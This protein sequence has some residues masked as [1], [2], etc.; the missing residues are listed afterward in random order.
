M[1]STESSEYW[2]VGLATTYLIGVLQSCWII[3]CDAA[4]SNREDTLVLTLP[5]VFGH[6]EATDVL[7]VEHGCI[8]V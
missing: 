2:R 1:N 4:R 5:G 3:G 8:H 7:V 6:E